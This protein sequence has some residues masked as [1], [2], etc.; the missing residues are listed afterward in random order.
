[1]KNNLHY[2]IS[3]HKFKYYFIKNKLELK[4]YKKLKIGRIGRINNYLNDYLTK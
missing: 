2:N 3:L 1:M 4:I